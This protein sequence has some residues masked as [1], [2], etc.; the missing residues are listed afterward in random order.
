MC[1]SKV[2]YIKTV[3]SG[4]HIIDDHLAA[5]EK[6]LIFVSVWFSFTVALFFLNRLLVY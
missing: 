2:V 6:K 1:R 5:E 4:L 3:S